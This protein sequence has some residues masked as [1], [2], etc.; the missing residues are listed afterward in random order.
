MIL[1]QSIFKFA[2]FAKS[3]PAA[4]P[5][6]FVVAAHLN[7]RLTPQFLRPWYLEFFAKP[8]FR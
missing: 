7:I 5:F 2:G 3:T 1:P 4:L 6:T 8:T